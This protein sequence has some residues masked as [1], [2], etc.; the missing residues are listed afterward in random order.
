ME[1][2]PK[3]AAVELARDVAPMEAEVPKAAEK[4][5]RSSREGWSRSRPVCADTAPGRVR[6]GVCDDRLVRG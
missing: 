3:A 4:A 2:V 1:S 5:F 6:S